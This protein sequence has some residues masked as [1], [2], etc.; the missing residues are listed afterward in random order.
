M[1]TTMNVHTALA[2]MFAKGSGAGPNRPRQDEEDEED[3]EGE[4]DEEDAI[5][6]ACSDDKVST[7]ELFDDE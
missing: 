5:S 1:C 2:G 6:H 7:S 4:E 3:E